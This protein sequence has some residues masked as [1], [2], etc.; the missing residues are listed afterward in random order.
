MRI[1]KFPLSRYCDCVTGPV[2]FR[3]LCH[4]CFFN[5]LFVC[6][7]SLIC[8]NVVQ[9]CPYQNA[10]VAINNQVV[11]GRHGWAWIKINALKDSCPHSFIL[12]RVGLEEFAKLIRNQNTFEGLR[13]RHEFSQHPASLCVKK[14]VY[15]PNSS[16]KCMCKMS[17]KAIE[18]LLDKVFFLLT[19]L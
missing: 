17:L 2:K 16:T 18:K 3:G 10:W 12:S 11:P 8:W 19:E 9:G 13:Y 15:R 5:C 4:V 1:S 7:R 6:F 14:H